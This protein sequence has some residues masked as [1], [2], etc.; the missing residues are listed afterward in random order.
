MAEQHHHYQATLPPVL[1]HAWANR[2]L[3]SQRLVRDAFGEPQI[4]ALFLADACRYTSERVSR[5]KHARWDL[6]GGHGGHWTPSL[7]SLSIG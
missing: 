4:D 7:D 2:A 1:S 6:V 5:D 3:T